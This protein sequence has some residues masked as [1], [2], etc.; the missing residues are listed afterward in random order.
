M[1][2]TRLT[3]GAMLNLTNA[4]MLAFDGGENVVLAHNAQEASL[5]RLVHAFLER[6]ASV[7]EWQLGTQLLQQGFHVEN[8]L[9]WFQE[10]AH[11]QTL[12]NHDY[13]QTLYQNTLNSV[14]MT[15]IAQ[16]QQQLEQGTLDRNGVALEIVNSPEA[17]NTDLSVLTFTHWL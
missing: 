15:A 10:Q 5:G 12:S 13:V 7:S 8:T 9:N 11:L 1:E 3:D 2:L 16:Y 6:S 14:N 4:E 17:Q